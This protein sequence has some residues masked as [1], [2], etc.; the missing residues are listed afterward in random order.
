MQRSIQYVR[1]LF[2]A[3]VQQLRQ[4]KGLSFAE[5]SEL[6]GLSVSYLNEIEKGKK[7]PKD[8]KIGPLAAALESTEEYLTSTQVPNQLEPLAELLRSG[9]LDDVP[10]DMFGID[11]SRVVEIIANAPVKVGAFIAALVEIGRRY[12]LNEE[13]FHFAALRSYQKLFDNYFEDLETAVDKFMVDFSMEEGKN[14]SS[15]ELYAILRNAYKYKIDKSTLA[16]YPE[17]RATRSVF[18]PDKK[19]LLVNIDLTEEQERFLVGKELGYRF[20]KV[21]ERA[22]TATPMRTANFEQA[23]NNFKSSYFSGALLLPRERMLKDLR[24]FFARDTWDGAA[25]LELMDGYGASPEMFLQRLTN[26]LPRFFGLADLF[27]LRLNHAPGTERVTLTKELH[28]TRPHRPYGNEVR[29]HYCRRWLAVRLLKDLH[30]QQ[31]EQG[32]A[33]DMTIGIQRSKYIGTD[34]EYLVISIARSGHPTPNSNVGVCI[35]IALNSQ[36][37]REIKFLNDPAIPNK[38]VGQTCE[39]CPITDCA[40]RVSAPLILEQERRQRKTEDLLH[41]II[42]E[43]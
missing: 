25:F 17:M 33:K 9:V 41:K 3:K 19:K 29:E 32:R 37:K 40:E 20:L 2:G 43:A 16:F 35:G 39:R 11:L 34:D 22:L 18:I 13:S 8:D 10:L 31:R 4:Q 5:L 6:C 7:Y 12:E 24:Q 42:T 21:K 27:F 1:L 28:L 38:I 30:K 14:A 36:L 15:K 26:L 23:L